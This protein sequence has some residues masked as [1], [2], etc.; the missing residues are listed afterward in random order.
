MSDSHC[1]PRP[2]AA[3]R[4]CRVSVCDHGTVH[5]DLGSITLRLSAE[6][7]AATADT[8]A[9]AALRQPAAEPRP[10]WVS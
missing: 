8:L 3:G 4:T 9:T 5:L 1:R 2:L 7:L 6:Q 10:R